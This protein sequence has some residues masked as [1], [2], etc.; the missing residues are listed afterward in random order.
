LGLYSQILAPIAPIDFRRFEP[1]YQP[2][3]ESRWV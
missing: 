3:F 2:N 1:P